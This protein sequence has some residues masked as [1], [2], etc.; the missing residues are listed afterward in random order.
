MARP[1]KNI[2][3]K[4]WKVRVPIDLAAA[5]EELHMDPIHLKPRYGSKSELV[6]T[7][8]RKYLD[9]M[10]LATAQLETRT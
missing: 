7:L 10:T 2:R 5:I 1:F 4:A 6:V 3:T 9:E 8:L